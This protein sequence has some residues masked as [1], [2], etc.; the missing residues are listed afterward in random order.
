MAHPNL[1]GL[2]ADAWD[3]AQKDA[4]RRE[5][6]QVTTLHDWHRKRNGVWVDEGWMRPRPF[7][8]KWL[9]DAFTTTTDPSV[10]IF[11]R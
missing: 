7:A 1:G 4:E 10:K 5:R 2:V 8:M 6:D 11:T 3:A 9:W